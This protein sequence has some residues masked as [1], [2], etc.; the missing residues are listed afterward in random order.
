MRGPIPGDDEISLED[1]DLQD[2]TAPDG[3]IWA[4]GGHD[5]ETLYRITLD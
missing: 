5:G 2:A 3:T 1:P 4:V